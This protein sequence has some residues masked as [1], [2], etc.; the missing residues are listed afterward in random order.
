MDGKRESK[1]SK[2]ATFTEQVRVNLCR[3]FVDML[4][5]RKVSRMGMAVYTMCA[6][7]Q[8]YG[9]LFVRGG[10]IPWNE[11][12]IEGFVYELANRV[13]VIPNFADQRT[14]V[15]YWASYAFCIP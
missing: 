4:K 9:T 15:L 5:D 10:Y 12:L 7:V 2:P 1:S 6:F 14:V 11:D 3:V 13:Q 8:I